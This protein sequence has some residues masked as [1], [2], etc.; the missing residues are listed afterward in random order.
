[1]M[2]FNH[3]LTGDQFLGSGHATKTVTNWA[4]VDGGELSALD[5]GVVNSST[6]SSG[7]LVDIASH[8][9]TSFAFGN[10][11]VV[12]SSGVELVGFNGIDTNAII[13]NKGLQA[14]FGGGSAAAA[15]VNSGGVTEGTTLKGIGALNATQFVF[16]GG[17]ANDTVVSGQGVQVVGSGSFFSGG[18]S[19]SNTF[20]VSQGFS[21][22]TANRTLVL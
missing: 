11:T 4:I 21:G 18:F 6:I 13:N 16:S 12:S 19:Q 20:F 1:M 14:V 22:G 7:G 15:T 2:A 5:H 3:V 9:P 8:D 17:V 10:A